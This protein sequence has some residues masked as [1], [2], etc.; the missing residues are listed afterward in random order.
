MS[1]ER[2]QLLSMFDEIER[3]YALR[4]EKA[5][6]K[7]EVARRLIRDEFRVA[8]PD[9]W[10]PIVAEWVS[11]VE[12]GAEAKRQLDVDRSRVREL[13]RDLIEKK[14]RGDE[15]KFL[16]KRIAELEKLVGEGA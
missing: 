10:E 6:M 3:P 16:K 14:H 7:L 15:S 11:G 5:G 13:E 12:S 9:T 8:H 2:S 1:D 4:A